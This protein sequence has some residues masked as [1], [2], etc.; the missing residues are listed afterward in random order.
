MKDHNFS[1]TELENMLPWERKI[2]CN[3]LTEQL[4]QKL[5]ANSLEKLHV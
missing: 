3:I 1:I 2:Y 5:E 4:K